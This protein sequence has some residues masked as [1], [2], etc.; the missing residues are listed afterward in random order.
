MQSF[1]NI[2]TLSL[3][4]K[5]YQV[6]PVFYAPVFDAPVFDAPVFD[7]PVFDVIY[8][9]HPLSY[10][11]TFKLVDEESA[12]KNK[13]II[14]QKLNELHEKSCMELYINNS[15][16]IITSPFTPPALIRN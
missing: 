4:G 13:D 10:F 6:V 16:N 8:S 9:L 12:G 5:T 14:I 1:G 2:Q 3:Y 7:A 11:Q 15:N